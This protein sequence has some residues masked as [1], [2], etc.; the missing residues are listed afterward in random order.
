[1]LTT[2]IIDRVGNTNVFNVVSGNFVSN[3]ELQENQILQSIVDEDLIAEYLDGINS[4]AGSALTVTTR[5]AS[6]NIA[7]SFSKDLN[8][9]ATLRQL[10]ETFFQQFFPQALQNYLR[11][12]SQDALF[13]HIAP[14]LAMIPFELLHDGDSFLLEKFSLGKSI[15]GSYKPQSESKTRHKLD[16]LIIA[17]PSEDLPWARREGEQL[18][19]ALNEN[20]PDYQIN[21]E[22]IGGRSATKLSLLNAMKNRDI[23]HY[24]GHLHFHKDSAENGWL[25]YGSK[26][27]HSREIDKSGT[28]PLLIFSNSCL[29]GTQYDSQENKDHTYFANAFIRSIKSS[30]I[31]TNWEIADTRQTL[32]FTIDF[33]QNI[34]KGMSIGKA[35]QSSR[36]FAHSSFPASDITWAS[37]MLLG[38]PDEQIFTQEENIPDI[39]QIT[40]NPVLVENRYPMPI[41]QA[42]QNYRV[43]AAAKTNECEAGELRSIFHV[44]ENSILLLASILLANYDYLKLTRKLVFNPDN[45]AQTLESA[46]GALNAIKSLK[47]YPT[48]PNLSEA[49]YKHKES[50]QK[51]VD[52]MQKLNSGEISSEECETYIVTSEFFM[53]SLLLDL[54]F[55]KHYGFYFIA[56]PGIKQLSLMGSEEHHHVQDILLPTQSH[57]E[58]YQ[59]ILEKSER[60]VG[61]CVFYN[62]VKKI[63]L[64]LSPYLS[65]DV[66]GKVIGKDNY[67]LTFHSPDADKAASHT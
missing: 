46:Y 15:K 18:Y 2:I 21:I 45:L 1:M 25:L 23:I 39:E 20:F 41:A 16:M 22:L 57:A 29:S 8:F 11:N 47:S 9:S 54:D 51:I 27:L 53:E 12:H 35:L 38:N 34:F 55:L 49:M 37:Y 43:I 5:Q 64:D 4:A 13:F 48:A 59:E 6:S 60:Y 19:E 61:H 65:L 63:F 66:E 33:Y 30:Y 17:D 50:L 28:R 7:A 56:E 3:P 32:E 52:W 36:L 58:A 14:E 26:V 67:S 40:L 42:F 62:P 31:G 10:G 24:A 44:F